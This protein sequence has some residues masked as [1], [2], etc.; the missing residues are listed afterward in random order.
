M[1]NNG[2]EDVSKWATFMLIGDNV[3]F[4]FEDWR[5]SAT[6]KERGVK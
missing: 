1:R 2:F 3:T 4:D 5:V 6:P